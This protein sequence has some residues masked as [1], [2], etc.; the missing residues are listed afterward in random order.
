VAIGFG[1]FLYAALHKLAR[2]R[3]I[4]V[5]FW[6][7]PKIN[8]GGRI[9]GVGR[10]LL[11]VSGVAITASHR[12]EMHNLIAG[13]QRNRPI[14]RDVD[15]ANRIAN[16]P[17]GAGALFPGCGCA[18]AMCGWIHYST[19]HP[20]DC[21]PQQRYAPAQYQQPNQKSHNLGKKA[22]SSLLALVGSILI[23]CKGKRRSQTKSSN[24]NGLRGLGAASRDRR[25]SSSF[26]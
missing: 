19:Q 9:L 3:F 21:A 2:L 20:D 16:Q 1:P 11:L 26:Y 23:V 6:I 5:L 12:A 10:K 17:P 13:A 15:A 22:A 7:D 4:A 25:K 24:F 14:F 8:F 18:L